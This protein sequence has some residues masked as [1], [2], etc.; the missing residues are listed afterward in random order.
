M[1]LSEA[2]REFVETARVGHL[3]TASAN[4]TPHIVPVCF[5]GVEASYV[6]PL[7]TKPKRVEAM[8]LRR[9]RNVQENPSGALLVDHY[10]EDWD[11]LGWVRVDGTCHIESPASTLHDG[12]I[13]ALRAK[14]HQYEDHPLEERP[15]LVIEPTQVR[16]WGDL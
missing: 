11:A 12:A 6:S 2:E 5:A 13:E 1:S 4:G 8:E 16:S 10:E 15:V 14:Y 9:V 3:A 7:D